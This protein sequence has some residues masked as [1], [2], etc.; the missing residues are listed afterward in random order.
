MRWRLSGMW[1]Q[2]SGRELF[3]SGELKFVG[4]CGQSVGNDRFHSPW[5]KAPR[6]CLLSKTFCS[7]V[8]VEARSVMFS[9]R[10]R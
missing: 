1:M 2:Q 7:D 6:R 5:P 8:T 9:A 10:C 4:A 3:D